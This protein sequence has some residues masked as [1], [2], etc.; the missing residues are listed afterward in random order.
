MRFFFID[1]SH[2]YSHLST[3]NNENENKYNINSIRNYRTLSVSYGK[4]FL[5][6]NEYQY[7]FYQ[8]VM[9]SSDKSIKNFLAYSTF[10]VNH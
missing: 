1:G 7:F 2:L 4:L 10:T 9:T 5:F 6:S 8:L 3:E